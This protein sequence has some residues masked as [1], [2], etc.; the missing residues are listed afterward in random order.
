MSVTLKAMLQDTD[1][2][3]LASRASGRATVKSQNHDRRPCAGHYNAV[4]PVSTGAP[5]VTGSVQYLDVGLKLEVERIFT[6]MV[7]WQ[8]KSTWTSALCQGSPECLVGTL[9]Y[10]I[11]TRNASTCCN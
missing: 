3:I 9:A 5:V 4:T 8:S 11:G 7:R 2:K 6:S 1:T 10:Q